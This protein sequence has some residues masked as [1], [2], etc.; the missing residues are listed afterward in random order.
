M[1]WKTILSF[2]NEKKNFTSAAG[3]NHLEAVARTHRRGRGGLQR[4]RG[5]APQC[6]TSRNR[7]PAQDHRGRSRIAGG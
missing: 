5:L 4:R 6:D 7:A 1:Q 3:R 2:P